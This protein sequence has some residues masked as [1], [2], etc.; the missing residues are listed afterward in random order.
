MPLWWPGNRGRQ[1]EN[2]LVASHL[3]MRDGEDSM[4]SWVAVEETELAAAVAVGAEDVVQDSK[5]EAVVPVI[6]PRLRRSKSAVDLSSVN[7]PMVSTLSPRHRQL[8]ERRQR[9]WACRVSC[10]KIKPYISCLHHC[11]K[12]LM[13]MEGL[14]FQF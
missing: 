11:L 7:P 12:F 3:T 5:V 8:H 14:H 9:K 4:A 13:L 2:P 6:A 1:Q 10:T